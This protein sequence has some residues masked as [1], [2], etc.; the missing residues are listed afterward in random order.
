MLGLGACN[1]SG[2]LFAKMGNAPQLASGMM[3]AHYNYG[4]DCDNALGNDD[5][6]NFANDRIDSIQ[7]NL[8]V[9]AKVGG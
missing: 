2:S 3:L 8:G 4:G 6:K 7:A 5:A 1:W 9:T